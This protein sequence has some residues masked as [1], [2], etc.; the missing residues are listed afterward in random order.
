MKIGLILLAGTLI[1]CGAV[2]QTNGGKAL[3]SAKSEFIAHPVV[4]LNDNAGWCWY[5]GERALIHDG[6]LYAGSVANALGPGGTDRKGNIELNV[7]DLR[8]GE[9][10]TTVL[11]KNLEEDDHDVP[12]LY[13]RT[14]GKL[15]AVW[16]RHSVDSLCRYAVSTTAGDGREF[17]KV[18][19]FQPDPGKEYCYENV[20]YLS[21]EKKL[22]DFFRGRGRNPNYMTSTNEG[23]TWTYGGRFVLWPKPTKSDP[24]YTGLDGSRPYPR[25]TSNG[26]DTIHCIVT[27]DHPRAYDNSIYHCLVKGGKVCTS[28]GQPIADLSTKPDQGVTFSQMTRVYE[29]NADNVAWTTDIRLDSAGLPY[30]A[31]SVQKNDGINRTSNTAGGQDLR[32]FYARFDGKAW[33]VHEI[34]HAGQRLYAPEVD[35]TGLVALD[36]NDP[37]ILFV[38][39]NADPVTGAPLVSTA[40]GQRHYEIFK[41]VTRDRGATWA[42]TPITANSRLDNLRPICPPGKWDERI[43]LWLRGKLTT[44]THYDLEAVM[45]SE[46]R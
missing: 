34:A 24:K 45:M 30:I 41:G 42:W 25:Y 5:Q 40:D 27:E 46:P 36:P 8:S 12:A 11:D 23:D 13:I 32:Y 44:F 43:V 9:S 18:L 20:F 37:D 39:T 6:K 1:G 35:Y 19:N 26:V 33:G 3:D 16:S 4:R 22:Y 17:K 7:R 31:F 29:G 2:A 10:Y 38:S 28:D 15:L 14:D 21:A